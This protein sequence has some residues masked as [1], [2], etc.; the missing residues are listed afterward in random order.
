MSLEGID[1]A[2]LE[3]GRSSP[4]SHVRSDRVSV[5]QADAG[6]AI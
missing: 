2:R 3:A 5:T 4:A 1:I 6:G